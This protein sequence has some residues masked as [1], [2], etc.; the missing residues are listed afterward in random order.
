[1]LHYV[2]PTGRTLIL[3]SWSAWNGGSLARVLLSVNPAEGGAT[4]PVAGLHPPASDVLTYDSWLAFNPG[5]E[6]YFQADNTSCYVTTFGALLLG[7]PT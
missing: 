3:H 4:A 6:L 2:V 7:E 5:D 1:V